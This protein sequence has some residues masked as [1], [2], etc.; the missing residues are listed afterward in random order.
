VFRRWATPPPEAGRD[1]AA[2][3]RILNVSGTITDGGSHGL[4]HGPVEQWVDELTDLAVNDRFDTFVLWAEAPGHLA[5][6]AEEVAPAV[7]ARVAGG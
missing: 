3:R 6:F 7:R 2:I 5:R 4:L 1:P